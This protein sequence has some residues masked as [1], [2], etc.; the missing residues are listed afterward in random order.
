MTLT[1][2]YKCCLIVICCLTPLILQA[3]L[4]EPFKVSRAD[5]STLVGYMTLPENRESYPIAFILHGS[6]CE[7]VR[8]WHEDFNMLAYSFGA[9]LV[10]L[11]K[12]GI[13]SPDDFDMNEYDS[14]NSFDNRLNDHLLFIQKL[15]NHEILPHWN[16]NII[17][18]GGSE[19]GR[20]AISLSAQI[21]EVKATGLFTCGGGLHTTEELKIAFKKFLISMGEPEE[22][23]RE[24]M[25]LLE[26]KIQE[27]LAEPVG[28]KYFMTCTYK[29]WASHLTRHYLDELL[30]IEHPIFYAHG[31]A[32][33]V[34]PVES[35]DV[36][37]H[38]FKA[39][40]KDNLVYMRL[41]DYDHDMR[42][43]PHHVVLSMFE[44]FEALK[45]TLFKPNIL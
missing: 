37:A 19:G 26:D 36:I 3:N 10:T 39:V 14:T 2:W 41:E 30:Q 21:P 17:L 25:L 6:Q 38:T 44:M 20:L 29:W 9:A 35:A 5:G 18:I 28:D 8:V 34:I 33:Q 31:S 43:F 32:D 22:E 45:P 24:M 42:V 16:G 23:I 1:K 40:G 13:Y 4:I 27:M 15:R 12:Q 11:E 7:S